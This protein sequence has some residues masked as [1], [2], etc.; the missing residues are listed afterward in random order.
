MAK[1][2]A[3]VYPH[4]HT[5]TNTERETHSKLAYRGIRESI[6]DRTHATTHTHTHM[7]VRT[8]TQT[9]ARA[10]VRRMTS[11]RKDES[12]EIPEMD[13]RPSLRF[14]KFRNALTPKS[15]ASVTQ[16]AS[17]HG[18]NTNQIYNDESPYRNNG[19]SPVSTMEVSPGAGMRW[20]AIVLQ[21][22]MHVTLPLTHSPCTTMHNIKDH[23]QHKGVSPCFD[24]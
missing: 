7:H 2:R 11:K 18:A 14:R 15:I 3:R 9:H 12:K 16:R 21:L 17:A 23:A 22:H 8:H 10:Y 13:A 19:G 1:V 4:T 24:P 5:H 20:L 6:R